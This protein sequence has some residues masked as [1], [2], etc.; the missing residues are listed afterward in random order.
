MSGD[1]YPLN[2]F[3]IIVT[4]AVH[5][6]AELIERLE[7]L[8]GEVLHSPAIAIE[9]IQHGPILN[10]RDSP[11]E[12]FDWLILTS[13]NAV[14]AAQ[15]WL[16]KDLPERTKIAAVGPSTAAAMERLG[17]TVELLA[18]PAHGAALLKALEDKNLEGAKLLLLQGNQ[19]SA[20]L[21]DGLEKLGA[22]VTQ[23]EAYR[24]VAGE[25]PRLSTFVSRADAV[26]FTSGT[27]ARYSLQSLENTMEYETLKALKVFSIGPQTTKAL[28]K[29]G[30]A[31]V[32]EASVHTVDGLVTAVVRNLYPMNKQ[33]V[34]GEEHDQ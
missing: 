13:Q 15:L 18:K 26:L 25:C 28:S 32:V 24:T 23:L 14:P 33:Q 12:T 21:K 16:S 22:A 20:L 10:Q 2:G 6:A 31:D 19:A 5:Q 11:S 29:M 3:K 9:Q 4:R 1:A 30:F 27:T 8:G 34:K 17:F 7:K